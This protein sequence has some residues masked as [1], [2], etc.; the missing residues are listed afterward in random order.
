M[1][2]SSRAAVKKRIGIRAVFSAEIAMLS[3]AQK[4]EDQVKEG[5]QRKEQRI[6]QPQRLFARTAKEPIGQDKPGNDVMDD[7]VIRKK[8]GEFARAG[9]AKNAPAHVGQEQ[10]MEN[11]KREHDAHHEDEFTMR[12]ER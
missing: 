8:D 5:N 1:A 4:N 3:S 12:D 9:H 7:Q 11:G 10:N 6:P 2:D